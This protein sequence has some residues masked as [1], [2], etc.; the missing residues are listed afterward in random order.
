MNRAYVD[1]GTAN[2]KALTLATTAGGTAYI[3]EVKVP[4]APKPQFLIIEEYRV[5]SF[6]G[7]YG[8]GKT[9]SMFSLMPGEE[10][11][12]S[13]RT[14]KASETERQESSS[15]FDSHSSEAL[16]EVEKFMQSENENK[17][18]EDEEI[19]KSISAAVSAEGTV[20]GGLVKA[21]V[22]ASLTADLSSATNTSREITNRGIDRS[23]KKHADKVAGKRDVTINTSSRTQ[24]TTGNEDSLTRV[25][26]NVN[27]SRT[28]NFAF[29]QL[30]QEYI[31]YTHLVNVKIAFSN[32]YEFEIVDFSNLDYILAKYMATSTQITDVKELLMVAYNNIIAFPDNSGAPQIVSMVENLTYT[33]TAPAGFTVTPSPAAISKWRLKKMTTQNIVN[34]GPNQKV[35]NLEGVILNVQKTI[36]PTDAVIIDAVLGQGE[37]LDSYSTDIQLQ[38]VE[39]ETLN[40]ALIQ[41]QIDRL[42]L[43]QTIV[44]AASPADKATIFEQ[45]YKEC[46]DNNA[47]TA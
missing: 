17:Y 27:L 24:T 38:K 2:Q 12:I 26:K 13:V 4:L 25:V 43:A 33:P 11:T 29:R 41:Q 15:V 16:D 23:L 7:D 1:A 37:A 32:G 5:T 46:C 22:S 28:L 36:L 9:L 30:N 45:V 3:S 47:P 31:T 6:L 20:N 35:F 39:T 19:L 21:K 8:A 34:P 44:N 14:F 18:S 42:E 40:N 10:A